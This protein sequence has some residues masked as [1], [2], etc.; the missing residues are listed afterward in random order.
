VAVAEVTGDTAAVSAPIRNHRGEVVAALTVSPPYDRFSAEL[1][2]A[3]IEQVS[4]AGRELSRL[5][6]Y[7]G[8]KR[9]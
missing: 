1:E 2:K 8:G 6:G 9:D 3:C 7:G 4:E 5:L